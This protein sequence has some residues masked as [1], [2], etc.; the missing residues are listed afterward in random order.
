MSSLSKIE[1]D[2]AEIRSLLDRERETIIK[3]SDV[4][5]EIIRSSSDALLVL[6]AIEKIHQA[7]VPLLQEYPSLES[8]F[9]DDFQ[10]PLIFFSRASVIETIFLDGFI[11]PDKSLFEFDASG[12]VDES[13][14]S[15]AV[16]TLEAWSRDVRSDHEKAQKRIRE[17]LTLE[18]R[19]AKLECH[20]VSCL[21][22]FRTKQRELLFLKARVLIDSIKDSILSGHSL[23][24][25]QLSELFGD[26]KRN[27]DKLIHGARK[28]F[29]R[30]TI[31]RLE[32]QI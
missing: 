5:A 32:S 4:E 20:C 8:F 21:A 10:R 25:E 17:G 22:D 18:D 9:T 26:F 3:S 7:V 27:L 12:R 23:T 30:S 16:Y 13:V 1:I 6:N 29:R 28:Y 24:L 31:N 19:E 11:F 14:L 2:F 15:D